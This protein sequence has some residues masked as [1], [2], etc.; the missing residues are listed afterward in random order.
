VAR[1][2]RVTTNTTL[3]E[4][5]DPERTARFFDA[6]MELGV[7][8]MMVSPGYSYEKAPDQQHFLARERTQRFFREVFSIGR[9][10]G[11]RWR[12]NQSPLFLEFLA[13]SREYECT[14]WGNPTYSVFGWQRPCYLLQEGYAKSFREL[15]EETA[16]E[17]YGRASGNPKCRDCM[18]H[19]GY[20]A[21]AVDEA[22]SS[23]RGLAAMARATLAGPRPDRGGRAPAPPGTPPRT[24]DLPVVARLGEGDRAP[25]SSEALRAAFDYRGNVTLELRDGTALEGYVTNLGGSQLDL[26]QPGHT[27][28]RAVPRHEIAHVVFSGRDTA[29]G[30]SW[31]TWVRSYEAKRTSAAQE[32]APA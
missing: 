31:E 25:A 29:S 3:F 19:C 10:L 16:W 21:S 11:R 23:W 13:G 1:G 12:F 4:G 27:S 30:K 2:F 17:R 5:A 14:P 20:E 15:V 6:M 8:G 22:F 32:P 7:E 28:T 24:L 26:W 18:V 9:R